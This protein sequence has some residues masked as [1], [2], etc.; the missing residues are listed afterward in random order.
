MVKNSALP[1]SP[2]LVA[3]GF[4]PNE[5][6][7]LARVLATQEPP[8]ASSFVA[9][10]PGQGEAH[11]NVLASLRK[12]MG[13]RV[14][15][16]T[17]D[18]PVS[19]GTIYVAPATGRVRL[20]RTKADGMLW[21][22]WQSKG[23]ARESGPI[24]TCFSSV[25]TTLQAQ[26]TAVLLQGTGSDGARGLE[27]VRQAGGLV[28][29]QEDPTTP[30]QANACANE[31]LL[32]LDAIVFGLR[33]LI[34]Q[35]YLARAGTANADV[36]LTQDAEN[37]EKLLLM[38]KV[39]VGVDFTN[40][41]QTTIRRRIW[42]R[43]LLHRLQRL[44]DYVKLVEATP[45]EL[46]L[47]YSDLL[48]R[49]TSFFRDPDMFRALREQV[50]P[51]LVENRSPDVGIRIWV[52]GCA[53]GEEVYSLA[54]SLFDYLREAKVDCPV[55][56]F[57]TDISDLALEKARSAIYPEPALAML[58]P[59]QLRR[60]FTK[61][62]GHFQINKAVRDVCI[63]A[64]Q[65]IT[66]DPPFS[67]L[68]LIS[69]R[70]VLI[71]LDNVLQKKVLPIFHYALRPTGY[72]VLGSSEAVVSFAEYFSPADR[73]QKIYRKNPHG[74]RLLVDFS[75]ANASLHRL[76]PFEGIPEPDGGGPRTDPQREADRL[77][78][79]EYVPS[80][81][82]VDG[83]FEVIQYR[84]ETGAYLKPAPG[85]PSHNLMR[86][87]RE[88]LL[89]G[90]RSAV[91]AAQAQKAPVRS[92]PIHVTEGSS[93]HVVTLFVTP[94]RV[95][96]T[97]KTYF[98]ILFESAAEH[99]GGSSRRPGDPSAKPTDGEQ[100]IFRLRQE[101]D[102]TKSYLQAIIEEQ[103]ATNEE[104][105]AANEE[106]LS[107]N[108]EL[109]STNEE[110]QTAKEEIQSANEELST[111][112]EELQA[113]NT[114]LSFVNNDFRNLLQGMN[115][116]IVMLENDLRIR[117][118]TEAAER[119]LKLI[120]G[121]LGRSVRDV[122]FGVNIPQLEPRLTGVLETLTPAEDWVLDTRGVWHSLRIL[123]FRT[124]DNRIDGLLMVFQPLDAF[125]LTSAIVGELVRPLLV[126]NGD[127]RV[128]WISRS[129][130]ETYG[131]AS[132]DVVGKALSDLKK[133]GSL[134]NAL[135]KLSIPVGDSRGLSV[136]VD[137][138]SLGKRTFSI[139]MRN[140]ISGAVGEG[141]RASTTIFTLEDVTRS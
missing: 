121:D 126:L 116:P 18:L 80:G 95:P 2:T 66:T 12:E 23:F 1:P 104:L 71:Y 51:K 15:E 137:V 76:R 52:P 94:V 140:V 9:V 62:N 103:E 26:S 38:L 28:F 68:D 127:Q 40:Y 6:G 70:N 112:N 37:F 39:G 11:K 74:N 63:F 109:Q 100:E 41:K 136:D 96:Q 59:D 29:V 60:F 43:M 7:A 84:G 32:P 89:S 65:N 82:L 75:S 56:F 31:G 55:Q 67:R 93:D 47:L 124:E 88:G 20:E 119:L 118:F 36:S 108:E 25:A 111:V 54:I 4:A 81:V 22:R 34:D 49:V 141:G 101:L 44:E 114:E 130:C 132:D 33:G 8:D 72:L 78:L 45:N 48:I 98:L 64:K 83:N 46:E 86:M 50:F 30:A 125:N 99:D 42:R 135:T 14:V 138:P 128:L 105:K 53:T 69:C 27:E 102:A 92:D 134:Q 87:A 24:D 21:L 13:K 97:E 77:A 113:R 122:R 61:I 139:A 35:P 110:L 129:F 57:G 10:G 85:H 58:P 17:K 3:V 106:I 90:I 16:I 107:S 131:L 5:Y 91:E 120:P 73:L 115:V 123:P 19:A 79:A 117:R 133:V